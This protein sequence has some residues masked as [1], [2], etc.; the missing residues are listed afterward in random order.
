M[1]RPV[2]TLLLL[3]ASTTLA[4]LVQAADPPVV[5]TEEGSVS[6][7]REHSTKGVPF[8]AYR[9]IPFAKPPTGKLRF[10]PPL[11]SGPWEGVR[12]GSADPAPC[13]QVYYLAFSHRVKNVTGSEDCL[14]LNV[15][16][17]AE[18]GSRGQDLPVMVFIHG[19][20]FFCGSASDY[21]PYALL[22][23]EVVLVVLQYRLGILG[24]LSTEDSVIPGNFGLLDQTIALRWVQRNIGHFGGDP[25][26]VTVFGESAGSASIHYHMLSPM[27]EGLFSRAI[28]QSGTALSPWAYGG[29]FKEVAEYV[30]WSMGCPTHLGSHILLLCLQKVDPG[31]L[32][33]MIVDF[34]V[35]MTSPVLLA[36]RVDGEYLPAEPTVLM[37]EGRQRKVPIISGTTA[38]EGAV[39]TIDIFANQSVKLAF[40]ENFSVFG[41]TSLEFG[42]G[43]GDPLDLATRAFHYYL[44]GI[45]GLR[46]EN[47]NLISQMYSDRFFNVDQEMV[48]RLHTQASATTYTYELVHRGEHSLWCLAGDFDDRDKWVCHADD[49]LYLFSGGPSLQ[50][51][52]LTREEDLHLRDVMTKL[53]VNFAATG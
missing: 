16:T 3:V 1:T 34:A 36:P 42:M 31:A 24:F 2:M 21:S 10:K 45:N 6:G 53:W 15:F 38:H 37:K 47:A 28:M 19:G 17:P 41:V 30:G 44:G 32:V 40:L 20:A 48:T 46:K 14:H 5:V 7:L 49:L 23:H 22:N 12:D 33:G 8:Y 18:P 13:L 52:P 50:Y 39:I 26:K 51:F 35:F 43:D 9:S 11:A 27:T 4:V 25:K 29:A